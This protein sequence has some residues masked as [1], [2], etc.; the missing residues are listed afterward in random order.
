MEETVKKTVNESI[1]S[2]TNSE[3]VKFNTVFPSTGASIVS[4]EK[5]RK[6]KFPRPEGYIF[7]YKADIAVLLPF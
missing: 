6:S 5:E 3:D 4:E 2:L 1:N 7:K